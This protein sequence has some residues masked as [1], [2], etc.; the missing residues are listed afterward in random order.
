MKG[1]KIELDIML[2][3]FVLILEQIPQTSKSSILQ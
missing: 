3:D 2:L 1:Y